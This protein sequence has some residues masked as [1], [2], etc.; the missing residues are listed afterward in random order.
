MVEIRK[1]AVGGPTT[2]ALPRLEAREPTPP[3][4]TNTQELR[5]FFI[6]C[7][8]NVASGKLTAEQ[9]RGIASMGQLVYNTLSLELKAMQMLDRMGKDSPRPVK[10]NGGGDG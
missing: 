1:G 10:F 5:K 9:C 3:V 8:C 7:M 6:D 2:P 4:I